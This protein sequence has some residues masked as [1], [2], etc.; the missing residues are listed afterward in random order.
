M[1]YKKATLLVAL[2]LVGFSSFA[3]QNL[4]ESRV[5][6]AESLNK[7]VKDLKQIYLDTETKLNSTRA[8]AQD[9]KIIADKLV[10]RSEKIEVN[11]SVLKHGEQG[12]PSCAYSTH[13]LHWNGNSWECRKIK[14]YSECQSAAPDE[15]RYK[16]NDGNYVCSKSP[17]GKSLD[18]YWLFRGY[19]L[20]CSNPTVG[21]NKLYSCNYKNKNSQIIQVGDSYCKS[22]KPS[23][24]KKT[25]ISNWMISAWSTCSKSCGGGVKTRSVV[26]PSGYMCSGTIPLDSQ[27]CNTKQCDCSKIET[28]KIEYYCPVVGSKSCWTLINNN[29]YPKKSG[30]CSTEKCCIYGCSNGHAPMPNNASI[31]CPSGYS[32][33]GKN[34][35]RVVN[36]CN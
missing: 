9:L 23:V 13:N 14:V 22:S 6:V 27:E 35:S 31:K 20:T 24:S 32:Y 7:T 16:D 26:C 18:Y 12:I 2:S 36:K 29:R 17:K 30:F 15:Y 21:Y 34:C 3:A 19:S 5:K 8:N 1:K 33:N 4:E 10:K 25:C 28:K 11:P